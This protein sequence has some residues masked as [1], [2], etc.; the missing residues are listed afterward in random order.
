MRTEEHGV[1]R[2]RLVR[3]RSDMNDHQLRELCDN[4]SPGNPTNAV[5]GSFIPSLQ[6]A[7]HT[8]VLNPT[9]AVG[10]SFISGRP[11]TG[12]KLVP[13]GARLVV[14]S[15]SMNDPPTHVGGISN[16]A[17]Q[18]SSRLSMKQSTNAVDGSAREYLCIIDSFSSL[19]ASKSSRQAAAD[20]MFYKHVSK[21]AAHS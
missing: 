16:A 7:A 21:M 12:P 17:R 13:N 18:S 2:L 5:G 19:R 3:T 20:E 14:C 6:S 15:L 10:G 1:R 11:S 8:P 9:N 4:Q